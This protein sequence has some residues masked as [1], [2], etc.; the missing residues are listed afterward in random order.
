MAAGW[1]PAKICLPA[2]LAVAAIGALTLEASAEVRISQ[3]GSGHLTV[4]AHGATL[5]EVLESLS[6]T[7]NIQFNS[8]PALSRVVS[9]TYS[10]SL[11]RVLSRL[12][13][14]FDTVIQSSPGRVKL[15]VFDPASTRNVSPAPTALAATANHRVSSNVDLDEETA[16][17]A[18][19][20]RNGAARSRPG[21]VPPTQPVSAAVPVALV[22]SHPAV[23]SNVDLD[24][25]KSLGMTAAPRSTPANLPVRPAVASGT[26]VRAIS[27]PAISSNVD[28]DEETVR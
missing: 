15:T 17:Q 6:A 23:S 1:A 27:H 16:Q 14:G 26:S 13:D 22:P 11:Q 7:Q 10:G 12:L 28:L 19:Q 21:S 4:E 9:G 24:E 20:G 25:E 8:S 2:L 5:H 18:A 3:R